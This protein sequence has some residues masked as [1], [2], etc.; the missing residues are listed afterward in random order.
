MEMKIPKTIMI[1]GIRWSVVLDKTI[2]GGQFWWK[3]HTVKIGKNQSKERIINCL[4]HEIA[5][6]IL[7]NNNNRFMKCITDESGNGDYLFCF[8]HDQFE[9]FMAELTGIIKQLKQ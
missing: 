8:N 1:G 4:L 2:T 6:V 7:V 9:V 3:D 5:E